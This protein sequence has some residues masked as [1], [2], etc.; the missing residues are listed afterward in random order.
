MKK[1]TV[2]ICDDNKV[3]CEGLS[4]YLK[5]EGWNV[6]VTYNGESA[7]EQL[8]RYAVDVVLLDIMLPGID[9]YEVCRRI[10]KICDVYII[11]LSAK[12][13]ELDRVVGLEIGADDYVAK[14]FS[15]REII[16]RINKAMAR[17]HPN[18]KTKKLMLAELTVYP[19]SYQ[20]FVGNQE[21]H[22]SS[23]EFAMLTYMISNAGKVLTREQILDAVWNFDFYGDTRVIDGIIKRLRKKLAID[24][25]HFSIQTVYGIGYKLIEETPCRK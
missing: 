8:K 7:L 11:M 25:V 3:L 23:K 2:L 19:D 14:P 10:R 22:V 20:V 16:I 24:G 1:Y 15:L 18:Q 21:I 5:E 12:S 6:I 9:G 4:A 13:Q 17:L